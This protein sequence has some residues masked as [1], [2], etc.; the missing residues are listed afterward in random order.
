M[1]LSLSISA[2]AQA[3]LKTNAAAGVYLQTYAIR[4]LELLV[5]PRKSLLE[6]SGPITDKTASTSH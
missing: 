4:H 6:I 1:V 3:R 2:E 5:A